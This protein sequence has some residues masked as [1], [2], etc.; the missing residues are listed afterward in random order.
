MSIKGQG[1]YLTL[2]IGLSETIES[3]GTK[4]HIKANE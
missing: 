3:F 4:F 2:A 1:H